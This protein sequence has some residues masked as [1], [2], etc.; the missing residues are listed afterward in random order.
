MRFRVAISLAIAIGQMACG[1]APMNTLIID[2]G[3][4]ALDEE[5][6]GLMVDQLRHLSEHELKNGR[7]IVVSHQEDVREEFGHRFRLSR[8]SDGYARVEMAQE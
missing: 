4:G 6:R 8:D 2:E 7:I 1:G 3:F 5:N